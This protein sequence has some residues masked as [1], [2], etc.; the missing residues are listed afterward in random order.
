MWTGIVSPRWAGRAVQAG[1][2]TAGAVV[3]AVVLCGPVAGVCAAA[4]LPG[5]A[6]PAEAD[7]AYHGQVSLVAGQLGIRLVPENRGPAGLAAATVRLRVS[8]ELADRQPQLPEGCARA[9]AQ[10]VVCE[11]GALPARGSG[12]HIGVAL[13][14]AG[15]PAEVLVRIDTFWNGGAVDRVPGNNEH[16]VLALDTGDAYAF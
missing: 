9:G 7:V 8:A 13:K 10:V 4:P 3:A 12:R 16:S 6:G 14:L 11:T 2:G 5:P 15:R 1:R